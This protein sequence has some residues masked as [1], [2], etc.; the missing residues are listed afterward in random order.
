MLT[1]TVTDNKAKIF[2]IF[3]DRNTTTAITHN[4]C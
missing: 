1:I 4:T 2:G 3:S